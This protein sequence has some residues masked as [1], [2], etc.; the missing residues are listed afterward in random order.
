MLS[1]TL[2]LSTSLRMPIRRRN[3]KFAR[4]W[5]IVALIAFACQAV[6][7][8]AYIGK[9]SSHVPKMSKPCHQ[10]VHREHLRLTEQ[11]PS[12]AEVNKLCCGDGCPMTNC[13]STS[14]M[15]NSVTLLTLAPSH[16]NHFFTPIDS[17]SESLSSLYRPPNLG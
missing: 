1:L 7:V 5:A 14:V 13:H 8:S 9:S 12:D 11:Q 3:V 2:V 15:L 16:A 17:L 6:G 10:T 4:F